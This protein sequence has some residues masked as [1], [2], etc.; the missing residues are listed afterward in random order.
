[1]LSPFS[2]F[3]FRIGNRSLT[4]AFS[5]TA[6]VFRSV[7]LHVDFGVAAGDLVVAPG[8]VAVP[9]A[10]D[11]ER[12][13]D[14]EGENHMFQRTGMLIGNE[15]FEQF[16]IAVVHFSLEFTERN[17]GG[18]D[19]GRFGAEVVDKADPALTAED[20]DVIFR[21]NVEMLLHCVEPFFI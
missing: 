1:L 11:E 2:T 5:L 15:I 6:Q 21:R 19:D 16:H 8:A 9:L 4:V 10:A 18:V 17:A 7:E 14:A 12:A 20:F 3:K 13:M